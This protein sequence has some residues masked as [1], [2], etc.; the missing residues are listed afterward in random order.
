MPGV[1]WI[2]SPGLMRRL[3]VG[4]N[5]IWAD[6]YWIRAVQ[7]YGDTRLSVDEKKNYD[8]LY[9]LLDITTSLD[10]H[11]NIAYRFGSIL[12][13]EGLSERTRADRS[14]DRAAAE[15]HPEMP[16]K[17]QYYHDAGFVEYWW[18]RDSQAAADWFIKASKLPDAPNWLEP[19]AASRAGRAR[20]ARRVPRG[21]D[22]SWRDR[23]SRMDPAG[24]ATRAHATRRRGATSR[25]SR[26][27]VQKF[28]DMNGRFP[29]RLAGT[30]RRPRCCGTIRS[31]RSD[32]CTTLD[33]VT[34][35]VNVAPQIDALSPCEAET[36]R[37]ARL[38]RCCSP[39]R[40]SVCASAAS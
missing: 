15:G 7:Y 16:D 12:L 11:F 37:D 27:L 30:R 39:S 40:C 36:A 9:P 32:T 35:S 4:F 25:S 2:Q 34:G 33:P 22:C 6:I 5:A 17:W 1:Q 38:A 3:A 14:S 24:G 28:F 23:R 26:P 29:A 20:R 21:V 18:R 10:P 8:Q 13:S 19:L 31:I